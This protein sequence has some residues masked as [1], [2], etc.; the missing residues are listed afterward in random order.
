M[1]QVTETQANRNEVHSVLSADL[2][3]TAVS[4]NSSVTYHELD[5]VPVREIDLL[6][7]LNHNLETL[8]GMQSRL[9]FLMREVR[10]LMKL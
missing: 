3:Q 8:S 9:Q 1:K 2:S 6:D 10:Y 4:V 7:Q 5:E